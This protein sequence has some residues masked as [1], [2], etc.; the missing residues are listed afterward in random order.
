MVNDLRAE[1]SAYSVGCDVAGHCESDFAVPPKIDGGRAGVTELNSRP[2]GRRVFLVL[3]AM[4]ASLAHTPAMAVVLSDGDGSL[5]TTAPP[6]DPGWDNV[7][8]HG[9]GS[10]VYLQ[11]RWVLT[12]DHLVSV[13]TITFQGVPVSVETDSEVTL[14]NPQGMD[15]SELTDLRLVRLVDDPGLPDFRLRKYCACR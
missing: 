3:I 1:R 13:E 9:G 12:V 10:A 14:Q 11:D 8:V 5:N 7:G 6:N 15:L 2:W 4:L